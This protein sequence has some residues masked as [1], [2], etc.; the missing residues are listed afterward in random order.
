METTKK[1]GNDRKEKPT[2]A[3]QNLPPYS[4]PMLSIGTMKRTILDLVCKG[5]N[6]HSIAKVV[7]RARSTVI[8]HLQD[9]QRMGLTAKGETNSYGDLWKITEQG[10]AYLGGR[11]AIA[12]Y[13]PE[14]VGFS[15][16]V[17][18]NP[19]NTNWLRDR[20]HN[21]KIKFEIKQAPEKIEWASLG[22]KPNNLKNNVFYIHRFGE[23]VTT[24]TGRSLIFQLPIMNFESPELATA[25]A[26]RIAIALQEK[27][28]KEIVGLKLGIY[29][30]NA[31][32]ISQSHAIPNDPYAKFLVKNGITYS[33]GIMDVDA[34]TKCSKCGEAVP[35]LEFSDNEKS[36]IHAQRYIDHQKDIVVNEVPKISEIMQVIKQQSQIILQQADVNKETASG[37]LSISKFMETQLPK[38]V[39][40]QIKPQVEQPTNYGSYFG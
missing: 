2:L 18:Q 25:E 5:G 35:E 39:E 4:L 26:G 15:Q 20:P 23:V 6:P 34:S 1:E 36:H 31:Q 9:M 28:E 29:N 32:L 13:E 21:I 17:R 14:G 27:Y 38:K 10:K 3:R 33:D 24:F 12:G 40:P 16:G 30:I 37:L 8:E 7:G 22:W 11:S 19:Q